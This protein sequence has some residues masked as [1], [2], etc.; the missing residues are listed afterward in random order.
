[1]CCGSGKTFAQAFLAREMIDAC[2]DP[3]RAIIVCF[4]PNRALVQ[5]NARNFRV[6][7]GDTVEML[8]VC[9]DADLAGLVEDDTPVV[10]TTTRPELI[11]AFLCRRNRPRIVVSTYQSAPTLR[12]AL[13]EARGVE[14]AVLLGLFDEAH[15]TAGNKSEEDLFAYALDDANFPIQKRAFFTAT[16]RIT[17][18]RKAPTF[19]MSN[20]E[21]FGPVAYT[22]S[23]RRGIADGNV[24]DYDLW[25]PIITRAELAEFMRD[26]GLEGE[27]RAAVALIA[28]RKV[29][30][31]TRQSRFLCYRQRVKASQSFAED[32]AKV[33]PRSFVAHVDGSTPGREREAMMQALSRGETLLSNC[34]AFVEGVDAPGLQGVVFVDPRK[35]V[36]DVV[37]AVGR[38][39]RPDEAD[40][41]KRGSIIA[42]ILAES[43]EPEALERAAKTAGFE[44]LVQVA[45][46]LRA[47]DDALEEDILQRSRAEGRGDHDITAL[48]GLEVIAPEGSG[49][50]VEDLARSITVVAMEALRDDF[51]TQVGRLERFIADHGYLPTRQDDSRLASWVA[52]VRKK[53]LA[54]ALDPAHAALLDGVEGWSWVGERTPPE[55]IAGHICAFRDRQQRMPSLKRGTGAE[56]DLHAYLM[57]GQ[58]YFLRRGI[59]GNALTAALAAQNLLFFAEEVLGK[60]AQLSGRFEVRGQG[61]SSEVWFMPV[62]DP[63]RK[64]IPV[65]R[66]GHTVPPRSF[67]VHVGRGERERL[68][69]L[70]DRHRVRITLVRAGIEQDP[71]LDARVLAWHAGTVDRGEGPETSKN[72]FGWLLARLADRKVSGRPAYS[73]ANLAEK[74][75]REKQPVTALNPQAPQ[76]TIGEML[77]LISRVRS[78]MWSGRLSEQHLGALDGAPGFS[79]VEPQD[80]EPHSV[81][82]CVVYIARQA[83]PGVLSD[84]AAR[85]GDTGLSNTLRE[86]DRLLEEQPELFCNTDPSM[87]ET[88]GAWA[89]AP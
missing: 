45:Q 4:V 27:D 86:L 23:F 7:F 49:V 37:Q 68:I 31:R 32:M 43:A 10:E 15:R 71:F 85:A 36:V 52:T 76:G 16:P 20:P 61:A 63:H 6:V 44:T 57:E 72:S 24:V 77:D 1:M 29:M 21:I 35:S 18:G 73:L 59:R 42:P 69:A 70:G 83:G 54:R 84:R 34:K 17:E 55:K 5:Q 62:L 33:F 40:P 46:A 26:Q 25:V 89:A 78:A 51:A 30:E 50:D 3:D 19:S 74:R 56:A 41:D 65:F 9:S 82:A 11:D 28:L 12:A 8:G 22:Y 88:L 47:N 13:A 64:T 66:S 75:I 48:R 53:H 58:E 60:R 14:A 38:L 80:A 79:W 67:R 87:R 2:E 39:S 81:A